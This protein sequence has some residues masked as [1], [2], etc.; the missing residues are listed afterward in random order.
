MKLGEIKIQALKLMF[1]NYNDDISIEDIYA[2]STDQNYGSYLVNMTGSINRCF[3]SIE[4]KRVLPVKSYT[5]HY[6][7]GEA[8]NSFFRFNLNALIPDFF[9]IERLIY[10][11]KGIY[12]GDMDYQREADILVLKNP[13]AEGTYR[14]LYYPKIARID[15]LAD[16]QMELDI[17]NGI[18]EQ[19]LTLLKAIYI[20]MMNLTRPAKRATGLK[21][22]WT[23]SLP[24]VQTEQAASVQNI[25]WRRCKL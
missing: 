3:S 17:P 22:Q 4:E 12:C 13:C 11:H 10:Q 7:D 25:V 1:V 21:R 19:I 6:S 20:V 24:G 5:L 14:L 23:Q 15:S 8:D 2:L 9:D 18:A 16:N